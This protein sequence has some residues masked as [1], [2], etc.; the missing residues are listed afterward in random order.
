[1]LIN[2]NYDQII[3]TLNLAIIVQP[4]SLI[5]IPQ[6]SEQQLKPQHRSSVRSFNDNSFNL[7]CQLFLNEYC[8]NL[9]ELIECLV[10]NLY[11]SL[12]FQPPIFLSF[13]LFQQPL[14][15]L[16]KN[17]LFW[18]G[19]IMMSGFSTYFNVLQRSRII[20]FFDIYQDV[21]VC[22]QKIFMMVL[23]QTKINMLIFIKFQKKI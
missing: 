14:E 8:L 13:K 21:T 10:P 18:E 5:L 6:H 11:F 12:I 19:M 15:L 2:F 17:L 4:V 1:M 22:F 9:L 7:T 23:T 3:C 20:K 16:T